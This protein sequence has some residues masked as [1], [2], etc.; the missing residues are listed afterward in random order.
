[1][2]GKGLQFLVVCIGCCERRAS[3]EAGIGGGGLSKG[4]MNSAPRTDDKE[5]L[6][7]E[8]EAVDTSDIAELESDCK[9]KRPGC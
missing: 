6:D 7:R 4:L 1:M 2:C 8:D 5:L 9:E 3:F